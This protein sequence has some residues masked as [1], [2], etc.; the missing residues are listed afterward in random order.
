MLSLSFRNFDHVLDWIGE[1]VK[2]NSYFF[3]KMEKDFLQFLKENKLAKNHKKL[4]EFG[5]DSVASLKILKDLQE[6]D[7]KE[8]GLTISDKERI[9]NAIEGKST[10]S[11]A[12]ESPILSTSARSSSRTVKDQGKKVSW[13]ESS[14]KGIY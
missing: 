10:V 7:L 5:L 13:K 4:I 1:E 8:L 3:T 14:E 2:K 6:T 9:I 11:T 12:V